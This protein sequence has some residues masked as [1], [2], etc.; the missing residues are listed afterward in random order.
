ME[1]KRRRVRQ[2]DAIT[3][4]VLEGFVVSVLP[5]RRNGFLNGWV[6]MSNEA[7]L[8]FA[9]R[10]KDFGEDGFG[11]MFFLLT[12]L[13]YE[14]NLLINQAEVARS[15]GMYRQNVQRVVKRLISIG[16]LLEG[17][18]A[19]Q[20]R[21]Y[22]LNPNFGWKGSAEN[23]VKALDDYRKGSFQKPSDDDPQDS[24]PR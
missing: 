9:A 17:P 23:H 8:I 20:S 24:E 22:R 19:G 6:A 1:W 3:G 16:V 21:T 2:V 10:R 18:K 13:D 12:K 5:K 7:H 4:E 15:L 14:N 11:V